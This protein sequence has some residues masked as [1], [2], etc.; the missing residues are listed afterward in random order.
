MAVIMYS[1]GCP[2]CEVLK[3]KLTAAGIVYTENNDVDAMRLM[4]IDVVPVL[5]VDDTLMDFKEAVS[6][7][8]KH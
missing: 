8:N 2:K 7:I 6:W 5:K 3:R 4:G 1:T